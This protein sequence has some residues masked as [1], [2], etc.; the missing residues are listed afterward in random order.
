MTGPGYKAL[1][2]KCESADYLESCA[3]NHNQQ[4]NNGE[5]VLHAGFKPLTD[6]FRSGLT[7]SR[8]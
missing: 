2:Y 8:E 4:V 1:R 6:G 7:H 3:D 5:K